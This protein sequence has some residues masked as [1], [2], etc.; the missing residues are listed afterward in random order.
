MATENPQA[1]YRRRQ[2]A[3]QLAAGKKAVNLWVPGDLHQY[4]AAVKERE[5]LDSIAAA[6]VQIL[7][8]VREASSTET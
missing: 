6:A 8:R 5:G 2:R 4:L 3:A 1:N 7:N